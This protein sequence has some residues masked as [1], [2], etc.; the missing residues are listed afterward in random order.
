MF[1]TIYGGAVTVLYKI[2]IFDYFRIFISAFL[3]K[4]QHYQLTTLQNIFTRKIPSYLY[5]LLAA[6]VLQSYFFI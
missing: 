4:N 1:A 2:S 3:K 6:Q 5:Y